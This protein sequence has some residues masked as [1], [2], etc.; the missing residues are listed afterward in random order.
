MEETIGW[1]KVNDE[2]LRNMYSSTDMRMFRSK[3]MRWVG[4]VLC[5]KEK[6]NVYKHLI[7]K[8][9]QRRPFI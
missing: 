6:L 8:P 9:E 2:E 4:H 3:R 1:R 7:V 5:I